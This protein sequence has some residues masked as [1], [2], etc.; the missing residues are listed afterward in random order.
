MSPLIL[1]YVS[2]IAVVV[3]GI[4]VASVLYLNRRRGKEPA[5]QAPIAPPLPKDRPPP[6]RR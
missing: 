2:I 5:G 4:I 1:V 6:T 3:I